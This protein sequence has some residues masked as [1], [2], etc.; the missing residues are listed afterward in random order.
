M[1]V[2][3]AF[4]LGATAFLRPPCRTVIRRLSDNSSGEQD[5]LVESLKRYLDDGASSSSSAS[6]EGL[7]KN[8]NDC[9]QQKRDLIEMMNEG[10]ELS[11]MAEQEMEDVKENLSEV[12]AEAA[13]LLL[14]EDT[15]FDGRG[16]R[17]EVMPGAGG[18]EA[19]VFAREIFSLYTG[20]AASLGFSV[21]V[22]EYQK[23]DLFDGIYKGVAKVG[24]QPGAF[25]AFKYEVGVHRVQRVPLTATGSKS[26]MLQTSTCSVAVLPQTNTPSEGLDPKDLKVEFMRSSG[27]GGQGVNTTDSACRI[28]HLPT[29]Q[30]VKAQDTRSQDSNRKLALERL[31]ELLFHAE[32]EKVMSQVARTRRSQVGS[33]NRNEKIRTYNYSR[34]Q[35]NDHRVSGTV[36]LASCDAFFKGQLGYEV[37]ED[38]RDRLE[39]SFMMQSLKDFLDDRLK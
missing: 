5:N 1:V 24:G 4:R 20:Y 6:L 18:M 10:G 31:S 16:A 35:L 27:A 17:L 2:I 32:Y 36:Q 11:E 22:T 9:L 19:S 34:H 14:P 12:I 25:R 30:A 29:G 15:S 8:L 33:M 38:L 3:R 28:L 23:T 13:H 37:L 39:E 7:A 21:D 26:S